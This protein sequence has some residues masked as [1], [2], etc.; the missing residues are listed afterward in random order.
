VEVDPIIARVI[1][2]VCSG[3]GTCVAQCPFGAISIKEVED[4]RQASVDAMLCKGC[5]TCAA[6]CPSG[7]MQQ[8]NFK[9]H[10][11]LAQVE[12]CFR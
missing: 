5:G 8:A 7:A 3:C 11:I 4:K 9:D 10:Q 1:E 12:A 6:A 2:D